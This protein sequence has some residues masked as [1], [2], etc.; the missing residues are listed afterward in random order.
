[1]NLLNKRMFYVYKYENRLT[2]EVIYVGANVI[3]RLSI[4]EDAKKGKNSPICDVIRK[5]NF[6]EGIN[7]TIVADKLFEWENL[8]KK[9]I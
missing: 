9:S 7:I 6:N 2:N 3:E 1:M 8:E 4:V 5:L